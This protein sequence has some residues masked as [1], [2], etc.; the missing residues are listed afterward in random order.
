MTDKDEIKDNFRS[1]AL[2]WISLALTLLAWI[3]LMVAHGYIALAVAAAAV[4]TGF[5]G[6]PGRSQGVRNLAITAIIASIVLLV[7]LTAFIIVV[8]V[9]LAAV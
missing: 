1:P 7:V 2:A 4:A 3:L 5:F 6:L 9:G 8:R